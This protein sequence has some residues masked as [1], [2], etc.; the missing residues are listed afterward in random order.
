MGNKFFDAPQEA[1][2]AGDEA[3]TFE[4]TP[5]V[6]FI[7]ASTTSHRFERNGSIRVVARNPEEVLPPISTEFEIGTVRK[8]RAVS[9]Q[10]VSMTILAHQDMYRA[11]PVYDTEEGRNA[12]GSWGFP[13]SEDD[14]DRENG[15]KVKGYV[16]LPTGKAV[17]ESY[18][19]SR[20]RVSMYV[21]LEE[22]PNMQALEA[23]INEKVEPAKTKAEFD[24]I[25]REIMVAD[26]PGRPNL[27]MRELT[28][29]GQN[30]M[31]LVGKDGILDQTREMTQKWQ[32]WAKMQG[33]VSGDKRFP[34]FRM[35]WNFT[36]GPTCK[37]PRKGGYNPFM[38]RYPLEGWDDWADG[39][40]KRHEMYGEGVSGTEEM[41]DIRS[42][43]TGELLN[44]WA[45]SVPIYRYF[46]AAFEMADSLIRSGQLRKITQLEDVPAEIE[47]ILRGESR[48]AQPALNAPAQPKPAPSAAVS[49]KV[50]TDLPESQAM[51][52][53]LGETDIWQAFLA[54]CG[55]YDLLEDK[56]KLL[57]TAA[58]ASDATVGQ[59]REYVEHGVS[60]PGPK[61]RAKPSVAPAAPVTESVPVVPAPILK[62]NAAKAALQ[63]K[64][65]AKVPVVEADEIGE[66]IPF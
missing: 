2:V 11:L 35:W 36:A 26:Y 64:A 16:N 22:D 25:M 52:P 63:A 20:A 6:S 23:W 21:F 19:N 60:M 28:L 10:T 45:V 61:A 38:I 5:Q 3:K 15:P 31:R 12:Q 40:K 14:A 49:A 4:R 44:E 51:I 59:V 32:D 30:T 41:A 7:N 13:E 39:L 58:R 48:R 42:V 27:T 66:E 8:D 50:W 56:A 57:W 47:R 55:A 34:R 1:E 53:I 37:G 62:T 18:P 29:K 24:A 43:M 54:Y 46:E 33:K 9:N 17:A 65:K